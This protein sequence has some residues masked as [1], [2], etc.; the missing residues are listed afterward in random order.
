M[1][2]QHHYKTTV[3]WTG[4]KGIG[5]K[6]YTSYERSHDIIIENKVRLS[7]SSDPSFRGDNTKHN[8]EELLVSALSSCHMLWYL[9]LCAN[10]GIIVT[11][12]QDM[13]IGTM[14]ESASGGG[15]FTEV[16]LHPEVTITNKE[17]VALANELHE[18]ANKNCFIANSCNF[19]VRHEPVCLVDE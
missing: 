17:D 12:Y 1:N 13:A 18:S 19:P 2:K 6:A 8:P 10:H 5:T 4:N 11:K 3:I 7:A 9:H 15:H 14:V 16:V